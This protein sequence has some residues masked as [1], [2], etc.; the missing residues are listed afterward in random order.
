MTT[1]DPRFDATALRSFGERVLTKAGL[2]AQPAESV[3][4]ILVEADLL[5]H[6][7]HGLTLLADYVEEIIED[8]MERAGEPL[9]LSDTGVVATWDARRLPGI[10]TTELAIASAVERA[11]RSGIG[12]VALQRSHHI[13]CLAAF[14]ERPA[15]EGFAVLVFSSDP[16]E[17]RVAPAGGA[18]PVLMP[19]PI[20]AGL[21]AEP[22]PVLIDISTSI[23]TMGLTNRAKR[24][25]RRLPGQWLLSPDGKPTDDPNVVAA[26]GS[27]LPVG[28]LD[29]GHKGFGLGLLVEM[30]TQGL[31]GHG[32]AD[33]PTD[34][35]AAVLALAV[36]PAAFGGHDAFLRQSSF[37]ADACRAAR[38][39]TAGIPVRLPGA[40][41]LARKRAAL[42]EGL[43]LGGEIAASLSDLSA[44]MGVA[45]PARLGQG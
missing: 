30:L 32:R 39:L 14:L 38:P 37:I 34:W 3:A 13:A 26:G 18:S 20:A 16:A 2:P 4:R 23:T 44:R 9:S 45:M 22:D 7:T 31:S 1:T 27:L 40:A 12:A 41:G 36:D 17:S 15:R 10:W 5:G 19:D 42:A 25:Q 33:R 29:H 35:G 43:R 21:P 24:Q 8:R 11:R 28:G 6:T